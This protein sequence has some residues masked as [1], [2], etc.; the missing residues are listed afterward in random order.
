MLQ[1]HTR[2]C[3]TFGLR[4]QPPLGLNSSPHSLFV[5]YS[6]F[7]FVTA[8]PS[9]LPARREDAFFNV[10]LTLLA[11][12]VMSLQPGQCFPHV[13]RSS[14]GLVESTQKKPKLYKKKK[15][16]QTAVNTSISERTSHRSDRLSDVFFRGLLASSLS[17]EGER[18][19]EHSRSPG[20][21]ASPLLLGSRLYC[22]ILVQHDYALQSGLAIELRY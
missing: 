11:D 16:K 13:P 10:I 8:E 15:R 1:T 9:Q 4:H 5:F 18:V 19:E 21:T 22:T 7:L 12:K 20:S 6:S 3:L 17:V 14:L 2:S